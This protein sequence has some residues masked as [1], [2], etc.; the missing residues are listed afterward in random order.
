MNPDYMNEFKKHGYCDMIFYK[1]T[2]RP[3]HFYSEDVVKQ[4]TENAN[5]M[6]TEGLK[7]GV[8]LPEQI[9][10]YIEQLNIMENMLVQRA[11]KP[12]L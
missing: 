6:I 2:A 1:G 10:D 4:I 8:R 7:H 11:E 9:K 3:M 5:E 12:V